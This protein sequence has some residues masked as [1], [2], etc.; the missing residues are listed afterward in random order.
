MLL[1]LCSE[2][3]IIS[4]SRRSANITAILLHKNLILLLSCLWKQSYQPCCRS[5]RKGF[6]LWQLLLWSERIVN[7]STIV[8][9]V[10]R[11]FS[12]QA[13]SPALWGRWTHKASISS[14]P[15]YTS[16]IQPNKWKMMEN[17]NLCLH[18]TN[19]FPP[20]FIHLSFKIYLWTLIN[21]ALSY[22]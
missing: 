3:T 2:T 1:Y 18:R 4:I 9:E 13:G 7:F 6:A 11:P 17:P 10:K 15:V 16:T 19:R 5:Q 21:L 12:A 20:S 22:L 8:S 14:E